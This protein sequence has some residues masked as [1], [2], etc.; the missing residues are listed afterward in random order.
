MEIIKKTNIDFLGKRKIAFGVSLVLS[1]M[2]VACIAM[3]VA[4]KAN[5]GI[6]FAGGASANLVFAKPIHI[7]EARKALDAAGFRNAELQSFSDPTK[8]LVRVKK[9]DIPVE[10]A[11]GK[12][13]EA[14]QKAFPDNPVTVDSS[15]AIGPTVGRSLQ[16]DALIAIVLSMLGIVIYIAWRFEWKFGLA[17]T[18][19]TFHDVL[20]V[21][22]VFL[23]LDKEITL[24]VVTA[25]L[26]LAGYSLTD[27]VVVFDRIRE[28]L[29]IRQKDNLI[30]IINGSINEV[31][32]RTIVTSMTVFLAVLSLY[33]LGGEVL[34]DFAFAMLI[35]V[36]VGT[37]SSIFVASPLLYVWRGSKGTRLIKVS[38]LTKQPEKAAPAQRL[39]AQPAAQPAPAAASPA[40]EAKEAPAGA[41]ASA[42]KGPRGKKG[43]KAAP[44]YR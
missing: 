5:M 44:R 42:G 28:N 27:T 40:P 1:L 38:M 9:V 16:K 36:V 35:G 26:T 33:I 41:P 43:K 11:V 18:V 17:A 39:A 31:L 10:Q 21:L 7:D 32:S 15:A 6:D 29:K 30:D 8:L 19:A 37:Y 24:L 4:G 2:G 12:M 25:L 14:F 20:A 13:Q 22:G 34:H 3:I 23:V